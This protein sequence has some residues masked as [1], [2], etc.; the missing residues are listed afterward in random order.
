[1]IHGPPPRP[2]TAALTGYRVAGLSAEGDPFTVTSLGTP[3]TIIP[4]TVSSGGLVASVHLSSGCRQ[5]AGGNPDAPRWQPYVTHAALHRSA[6]FKSHQRSSS[7][8]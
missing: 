6:S 5:Q 8:A 2:R 1:M 3:G 7:V 4:N